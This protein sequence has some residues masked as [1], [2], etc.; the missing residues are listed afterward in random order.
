MA[1]KL[2]DDEI[3]LLCDLVDVWRRAN[4]YLRKAANSDPA[5]RSARGWNQTVTAVEQT[6]DRLCLT[7]F[8]ARPELGQ[9][10][11]TAGRVNDANGLREFLDRT[12]G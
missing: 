2:T 8:P 5:A 1:G 4:H 12:L 11:R 10:V 6:I 9:E 3:E 7:L